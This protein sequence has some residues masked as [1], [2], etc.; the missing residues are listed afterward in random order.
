[1]WFSGADSAN[2][3][4]SINFLVQ[5]KLT[6]QE[7]QAKARLTGVAST[8]TVRAFHSLPSPAAANCP[9]EKRLIEDERTNF[10]L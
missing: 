5:E 1:M 4:F 8:Y 3:S 6:K 9:G 2:A 7:R 10:K